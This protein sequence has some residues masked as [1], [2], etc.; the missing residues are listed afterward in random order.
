VL[1]QHVRLQIATAIIVIDNEDIGLVIA[2]TVP[3]IASI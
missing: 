2:H 1:A 3:A